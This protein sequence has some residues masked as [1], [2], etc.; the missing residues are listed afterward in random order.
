[1]LFGSLGLA[2][3]A[4]SILGRIFSGVLDLA[5]SLANILFADIFRPEIHLTTSLHRR[6]ET[7][8]DIPASLK[9]QSEVS[10]TITFSTDFTRIN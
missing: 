7:A 9:S 2:G 8:S 10:R 5:G 1:L 3:T 6:I 4:V